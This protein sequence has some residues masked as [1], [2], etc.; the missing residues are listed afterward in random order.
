MVKNMN[1]LIIIILSLVL[2][3]GT[4]FT[5]SYKDVHSTNLIINSQAET[6]GSHSITLSSSTLMSSSLTFSFPPAYGTDGQVMSTLTDGSLTFTTPASGGASAAGTL[7]GEVQFKNSSSFAASSSF[8]WDNTNKFLGIGTSSP[9]YTLDIYGGVRL[10]GEGKDGELRF[11]SEQGATDYELVFQPH[12]NMTQSVTYT[13]P[14]DDGT[15]GQVLVTDGTGNLSWSSGNA[16]G[17]FG[18]SGQGTGGGTN[19]TADGNESFIGGGNSNT[20][21]ADHSFIGGGDNNSTGDGADESAIVAG[22]GNSILGPDGDQSFIGGGQ[23]NTISGGESAIVAG[24]N[25]LITSNESF[26]GGGN[27]NTITGGESAIVAGEGNLITGSESFIGA[28]KNNQI[29][30]DQAVIGAG[31]D[32]TITANADGS[33]IGAGSNNYIYESENAGILAGNSNTIGANATQSAIGAGTGNL[34]TDDHCFIGA[35]DTNLITNRHSVIGGGSKNTITGRFGVIIGGLENAV[36]ADYSS[37]L[38]G[39]SNTVSGTNSAVLGGSDNVVSGNYS[40]AF[41]QNSSATVNYAVALGRRA[42]ADHTGSFVL[43]D[44]NDADI[45]S[46]ANNSFVARYTG[47]LYFFTTT[48]GTPKVRITES[49][50]DWVFPSDSSLKEMFFYPNAEGVFSKLIELPISSWSYKGFGETGLRNYGPMAQDFYK[51]FGSDQYGTIGTDT[52]IS[53]H[54]LTSIGILGLQGL[55]KKIEKQEQDIKLMQEENAHYKKK[56]EEL[57]Q[58]LSE[59]ERKYAEKEKTNNNGKSLGR[60]EK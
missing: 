28:G 49:D 55:Y 56:I 43:A 58:I 22:S 10:G 15:D 11:Y 60:L 45:N 51:L 36:T 32:N 52:T 14:A 50:G 23:N 53:T 47:G 41:G 33:F 29:D 48:G 27:S 57:S 19:N 4:A 3:F 12:A 40:M 42:K 7:D 6:D 16:G 59:I 31:Q 17:G 21:S 20:A 9:S 34:I 39:A 46:Q 18:C 37:V 30:S 13:W 1:F 26:I 24:E 8:I 38:G 5:Q 54:N 35:G 44:G 25:N 2:S